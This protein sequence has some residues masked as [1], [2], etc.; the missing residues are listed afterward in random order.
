[1]IKM[2]KFIINWKI[3]CRKTM[4]LSLKYSG[5]IIIRH[6]TNKSDKYRNLGDNLH[7]DR[8]QKE[9][10]LYK[11]FISNEQ[12]QAFFIILLNRKSVVVMTIDSCTQF[13]SSQ[14]DPAINYH[15]N[16]M[17]EEVVPAPKAQKSS[18]KDF[19]TENLNTK[20]PEAPLIRTR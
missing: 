19:A 3:L 5:K 14:L 2:D 8:T 15:P 11:S 16:G 9:T 20:N 7:S 12:I 1:M 17:V 13:P 18:T 10:I 6:Q 4:L